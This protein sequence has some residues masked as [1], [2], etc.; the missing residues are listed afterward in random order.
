[1]VSEALINFIIYI[2][3]IAI[4][5][6]IYIVTIQQKVLKR[7]IDKHL[8]KQKYTTKDKAELDML[9]A[10]LNR[11]GMEDRLKFL[12]NLFGQDIKVVIGLT[13]TGYWIEVCSRHD[14]LPVMYYKDDESKAKQYTG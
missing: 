12:Y 8:S 7:F 2:I 3:I 10:T 5:L 13:S 1:M 9:L 6:T 14:Q 4:L 11:L